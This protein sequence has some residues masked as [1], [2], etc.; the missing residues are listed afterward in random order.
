MT[1]QQIIALCLFTL[2]AGCA[3][4]AFWRWKRG[5]TYLTSFLWAILQSYSAIIG[6][7]ILW[8]SNS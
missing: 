2:S 8:G 6:G 5:E 1:P 4:Y 3:A 7:L